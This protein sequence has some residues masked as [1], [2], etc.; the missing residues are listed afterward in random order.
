M[1]VPSFMTEFVLP[2]ALASKAVTEK[3]I[4]MDVKQLGME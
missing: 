2:I 1:T 4:V 3:L